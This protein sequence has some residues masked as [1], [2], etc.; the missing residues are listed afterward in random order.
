MDIGGGEVGYGVVPSPAMILNGALDYRRGWLSATATGGTYRFENTSASSGFGN[1]A[2]MLRPPRRPGFSGELLALGSASN[3]HEFYRARRLEGRAGASWVGDVADATLRYGRARVVH[4]GIGL[5]TNRIEVEASSTIGPA[6]LTLFGSRSSFNDEMSVVRDTTY[7]VAGFPFRG[8]YDTEI[9]VARAYTDAEA[10]VRWGLR[11]SVWSLA[12]GARRGDAMTSG[13][14]WQR[15][16]VTV[17]LSPSIALI[18]TGGR[19]PAVPEERL[20]SGAFAV[21]G[22]QLSF[23]S[24]QRPLQPR[25]IDG[26]DTPR[27][28][29]LDVGGGKRSISVIGLAAREVEVMSDFTDWEPLQLALIGERVWHITLPIAPGAHRISIRVDG[30]RW[31]PPPGLPVTADEFMG[32]VGILLIE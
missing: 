30:Q 1:A 14:H 9:S 18:A 10:R 19:R 25:S 27:F 3:H 2:I 15:L 32:A 6:V 29:V 12:V 23:Q 21:F 24:E 7:M 11:S 4:D 22:V 13:E 20:P 16:D 5:T 17:P 8:R 26:R 28:V 31:M